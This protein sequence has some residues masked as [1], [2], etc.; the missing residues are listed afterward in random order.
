[1]TITD[2]EG[3]V[4]EANLSY[5]TEEKDS[6]GN[7]YAKEYRVDYSSRKIQKEMKL[8]CISLMKS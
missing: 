1:M 8:I 7:V 4:I 2:K 6:I 3:Q 5:D